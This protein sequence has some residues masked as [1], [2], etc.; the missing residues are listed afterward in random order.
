[1]PAAA[2]ADPTKTLWWDLLRQQTLSRH[3]AVLLLA[4]KSLLPQQVPQ[5]ILVGSA[6]A[7]AA[8][9]A[10]LDRVKDAMHPVHVVDGVCP[11]GPPHQEVGPCFWALLGH[12]RAYPWHV[13][14]P[15]A[16]L[17]LH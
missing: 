11:E 15:I 14:H 10:Y 16:L 3:H 8:A 1:M 12:C 4:W 17:N 6:V 7:A 2:A 5:S 13:L 9:A